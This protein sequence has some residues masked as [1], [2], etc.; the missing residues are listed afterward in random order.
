MESFSASRIIFFTL[1]IHVIIISCCCL[2]SN[3]QFCGPPG[4]SLKSSVGIKLKKNTP[5]EETRMSEDIF[6]GR[7]PENTS[8][9]YH[10]INPYDA[11][12]GPGER[13]CL[14]NK[15]TGTIPRCGE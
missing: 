2:V 5:D 3:G 4:H 1:I 10:C 9:V 7:Y 8:A 13:T 12:V 14:M 15:W 11:L 6:E